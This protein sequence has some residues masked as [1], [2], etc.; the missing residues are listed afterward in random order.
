MPGHEFTASQDEQRSEVQL[1]AQLQTSEAYNNPDP[2]VYWAAANVM[3]GYFTEK[4]QKPPT[5][6][7]PHF[8]HAVDNIM[9]TLG[10]FYSRDESTSRATD[11]PMLGMHDADDSLVQALNFAYQAQKAVEAARGTAVRGTETT[12]GMLRAI[13]ATNVTGVVQ[14][15]N[16]RT[17][18]NKISD[19]LRN[20]TRSVDTDPIAYPYLA[21]AGAAAAEGI[22][23]LSG[24]AARQSQ[25]TDIVGKWDAESG[26]IV[27]VQGDVPL[28][29][30]YLKA[31]MGAALESVVADYA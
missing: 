5:V 16:A 24:I 22:G 3:Q 30:D 23:H 14:R 25:D 18:R 6:S 2:E 28:Y 9:S 12:E 29:K 17:F 19:V 4:A 26:Q 1:L 7:D 13:E 11:K 21:Q 20:A 8:E 15:E 10:G 27:N 31:H